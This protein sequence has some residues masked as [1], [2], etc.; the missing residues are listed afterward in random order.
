MV[1]RRNMDKRAE[2]LHLLV[3]GSSMRSVTRILGV[4]INTVARLLVAAGETAAWYHDRHVRVVRAASVQ[5]DETWAYTYAHQPRVATALAAPPDAGDIW[6]WIA[7]ASE[8][9]LAISWLVG[10]RENATARVFM[11]DLRDRLADDQ[12]VQ[13]NTD[14]YHAYPVAIRAAFG[15][16]VDY[17]QLLKMYRN[18]GSRKVCVASIGRPVIGTPDEASI[19][20][21]YIERQNLTIRMSLKRC[22]RK[23]NAFSKK[24]SRHAHALA[25]YFLY[26]NWCRRHQ[27]LGT[28]PAVA[29]GLATEQRDM[30][31][32]VAL[33][34]ARR[35][36]A[37]T[38]G[39]DRQPRQ[40]R[41]DADHR[42][43]A[44]KRT[45]EVSS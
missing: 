8:T 17:G 29:S 14:G 11:Q 5:C 38:R 27:T 42:R 41:R 37:R 25:L 12:R 3:E 15:D 1:S 30:D 31:W 6:T 45:A 34:E 4:G 44:S 2:I 23:T 24:V 18:E 28:T 35:R 33:V 26:Y 9:K 43:L 16:A 20:T 7:L 40:S 21:S 13:I 36:P 19:T 32:V 10:N 22:V 39:P